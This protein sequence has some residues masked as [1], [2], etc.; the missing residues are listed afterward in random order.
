MIHY[1]RAGIK[2]KV[3]ISGGKTGGH[4]IPGIAIYEELKSRGI[5]CH[6]ILS[7]TDL[8]FPITEKILEKDRSLIGLKGISRK[9]SLK[10]PVYLF[11][12]LLSLIK[13]YLIIKKFNPIM[14]IITGG[15]ISNPVALIAVLLRKPL[16]IAEQN[17]VAGVTNSFYANFAKTIFTNYPETKKIPQKKIKQT[18]SPSI[19]KN[20]ID[21]KQA[22]EFF[23]MGD[24]EKVIAVSGGSQ[25]SKLINDCILKIIPELTKNKIGLIWSAGSVDYPRLKENGLLDDM[26]KNNRNVKV[27]QFIEK[28]DYLFSAADLVVSR[29]GASIFSEFINFELPSLLIPIKNSPDNHQYLNAKFLESHGAANILTEDELEPGRLLEEINKILADSNHYFEKVRL[30]KKSLFL[31]RP[32]KRIVDHILKNYYYF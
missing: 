23:G 12:M 7:S 11:K 4:L 18:G 24:Y 19:F 6:Y 10:T 14:V 3:L 2:M 8:Q 9:L 1:L 29:A 22:K 25:G 30:V 15:Y 21:K 17:S 20:R 32:E 28:M 31:E 26:I 27:Y 13:V 16:Y 5:F